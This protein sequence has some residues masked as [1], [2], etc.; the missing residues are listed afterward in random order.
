MLYIILIVKV[1]A[2]SQ[3]CDSVI[4]EGPRVDSTET[5]ECNK[6][7]KN[8]LNIDLENI[9][10][11]V[12]KEN[13]GESEEAPKFIAQPPVRYE[14]TE[15]DEEEIPVLPTF[16]RRT[17]FGKDLI[18]EDPIGSE[19]IGDVEFEVDFNYIINDIEKEMVDEERRLPIARVLPIYKTPPVLDEQ[20]YEKSMT[21]KGSRDVDLNFI[22]VK[23]AG[24]FE[25][26]NLSP[27]NRRKNIVVGMATTEAQISHKGMIINEGPTSYNDDIYTNSHKGNTKN[28]DNVSGTVDDIV[29]QKRLLL[30]IEQEER[31]KLREGRHNAEQIN[32]DKSSYSIRHG[33]DTKRQNNLNDTN[34]HAGVQRKDNRAIVEK[35]GVAATSSNSGEGSYMNEKETNVTGILKSN[36]KDG[37]NKSNNENHYEDEEEKRRLCEVEDK[38]KLL[39]E[40]IKFLEKKRQQL[41]EKKRRERDSKNVGQEHEV[42][43]KQEDKKNNQVSEKSRK[44][45]E[46]NST[47]STSPDPWSSSSKHDRKENNEDEKRRLAEALAAKRKTEAELERQREEVLRAAEERRLEEEAKQREEQEAAKERK[48]N[49]LENL[50]R[51]KQRVLTEEEEK[52]KESKSQPKREPSRAV[53]NTGRFSPDLD[54]SNKSLSGYTKGNDTSAGVDSSNAVQK[55]VL[56]QTR[57]SQYEANVENKHQGQNEDDSST[58]KPEE[59]LRNEEDQKKADEMR[60]E[61][62]KS[63]RELFMKKIQTEAEQNV[64]VGRRE[65][66]KKV[67]PK[68]FY[69]GMFNKPIHQIIDDSLLAQNVDSTSVG[70]LVDEEALKQFQ[71]EQELKKEHEKVNKLRSSLE[72]E[73]SYTVENVEQLFSETDMEIKKQAGNDWDNLRRKEV[74]SKLQVYNDELFSGSG[75]ESISIF[76]IGEQAVCKV[77]QFCCLYYYNLRL[78][79]QHCLVACAAYIFLW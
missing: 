63:N 70:D 21:T 46:Q 31:K 34:Y 79:L 43:V 47:S 53:H 14:E 18:F 12:S 38:E 66:N 76:V 57:S 27:I 73:S 9:F 13:M 60:R 19:L 40:R 42:F 50:Q 41:Y 71:R 39:L 65:N 15:E 58:V 59:N 52:S 56:P 29:E 4:K 20:P 2:R 64:Q 54:S 45:Q 25:L 62:F 36:Q 3:D 67:R 24:F 49:F 78:L 33:K 7:N 69:G 77:L 22:D 5:I 8:E 32:Y 23:T 30:Q 26:E 44:H 51:L 1:L 61:N 48:R 68:S 75:E 10:E 11:T 72:R 37:Y 55:N 28:F 6:I 74:R 35:E 17:Y 16:R